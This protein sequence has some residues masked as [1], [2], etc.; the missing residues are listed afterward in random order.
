M[1]CAVDPLDDSSDEEHEDEPIAE[2][3]DMLRSGVDCNAKTAT[4][5]RSGAPYK[6]KTVTV[7]GKPTSIPTAHAFLKFQAAADRAGVSLSINSGFRTM[8]QQKYLYNCY[9]TKRCNNGN[10]AAKPGYSNHQSGHALDL[11][12][13][14]GALNW[15]NA[16]GATYG[17]K[18]TVPSENWHWEWWG[19]GNPQKY[20][21]CDP[22]PEI[23][24]GKDNDCDG[25]VD[26]GEVCEQQRLIDLPVAYAPPAT[27]DVTRRALSIVTLTM[28]SQPAILA[29]RVFSS[30]TGFPSRMPASAFGCSRKS[31]PCQTFTVSRAAIPVQISFRPPE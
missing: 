25:A 14:G 5:Y 30:W 22:R 16:H 29:I 2:S 24:D 28:K 8:D 23:C 13:G 15:L 12:T 4:G 9:Q 20:C 21:G 19:G 7:G 26:E 11:N 27:T 18:R 17:W 6:L 3:E 10:L 31:G 1:A